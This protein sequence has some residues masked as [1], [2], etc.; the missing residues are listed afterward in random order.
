MGHAAEGRFEH[1]AADRFE[2]HVRAMPTRLPPDRR[3]GPSIGGDIRVNP[4]GGGRARRR[5][6]PVDADDMCGTEG[7]SEL[8]D[9]APNPA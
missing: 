3:R 5:R 9:G 2:D 8:R 1:H 7:S 6:M 4:G